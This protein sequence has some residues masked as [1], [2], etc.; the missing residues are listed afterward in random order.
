MNKFLEASLEGAEAIAD[1]L[2]ENEIVKSI[3]V[4]GTAIKI[5]SGGLDLR[6]KIFVSKIQ[7]F[8]LEIDSISNR[9]KITFS[10]SVLSNSELM[11]SVGET[12]LLV[13][14]KL[15]DL[16]KAE[17][18]GFYF[19]CFLGGHLD[20]YQFKRI[21]VAIDSAY[22]DDI[23]VFLNSGQ[24]ELLSQKQFMMSLFSSGITAITA[25]KKISNSGELYFEASSMGC[26]MI[27]LWEEHK[28]R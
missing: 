17:L 15:S 22:I 5:L 16:S 19:S 27:E 21:A 11:S 1:S 12:A 26:Q 4:V 13:I 10:E 14:D 3:P 2:I 28:K 18:L 24:D 8:I 6:D 25:G 23:H 9:E 20:Q 7:R